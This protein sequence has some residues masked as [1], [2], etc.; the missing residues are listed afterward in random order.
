MIFRRPNH[1][2][3]R[4]DGTFLHALLLMVGVMAGCGSHPETP[5]PSPTPK[6]VQIQFQSADLGIRLI[7]IAGAEQGDATPIR[8]PGWLEYRMEIENRGRRALTVHNVKLLSPQGQY[9][10]SAAEYEA[11]AAPPDSTTELAQDIAVRSAGI[12]AGQV[13]PFGGTIVGILSGAASAS[14]AQTQANAKREF[15]LRRIKE[16]ELAPGGHMT[17]SA[18]LPRIQDPQTL[19]LDWERGDKPQRVELSLRGNR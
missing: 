1:H 3:R 18:F 4:R 17:G 10:D 15:A 14:S 7:G 12:A 16:I 19:V 9:L 11:L 2:E 5:R 13:I 6:A 8:D